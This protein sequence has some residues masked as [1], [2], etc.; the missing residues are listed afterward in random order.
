[1]NKVQ[2]GAAPSPNLKAA[3][4]KVGSLAN[5][6]HKPGGG[7]IRIENH[8]IDFSKAQSRIEAKNDQYV[9]SGGDKKVIIIIIYI[10]IFFFFDPFS[11]KKIFF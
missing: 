7:N 4:S 5:T 8:K 10:K 6:L 1:M 2:V 3:K 9:R 11:L